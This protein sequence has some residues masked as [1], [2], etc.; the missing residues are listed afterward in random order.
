[1]ASSTPTTES[2]T[3]Q[4]VMVHVPVDVARPSSLGSLYGTAHGQGLD[5]N[6]AA[7]NMQRLDHSPAAQR[8]VGAEINLTQSLRHL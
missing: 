6:E 8:E 4:A 3:A 1:M 7:W 2:T 5:A